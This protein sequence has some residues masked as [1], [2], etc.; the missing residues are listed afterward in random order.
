MKAL[1]FDLYLIKPVLIARTEPGDE[2]SAE[3]LAY[4]PGSSIRGALISAYMLRNKLSKLDLK[5]DAQARGWFFNDLC[6]LNAYPALEGTRALPA[7]LSWRVEK[8]Y[9]AAVDAEIWDAAGGERPGYLQTPATLGEAFSAMGGDGSPRLADPRRSM[10]IHNAS[11]ERRIKQAGDS[12]VFLYDALAA[13]QTFTA[14]ITGEA[15]ASMAEAVGL[16]DGARFSLGRSRSAHYGLVE[17]RNLRTVEDWREGDAL[18]AGQQGRLAL[19][20]A[21]D[22]LLYDAQGQPAFNL[23][24]EVGAPHSAA[25]YRTRVA[26]GFNRAWGL[27]LPQGLAIQAGSVFLYDLAQLDKHKLNELLERG[28]GDRRAEGFGRVRALV[29]PPVVLQRKDVAFAWPAQEQA[30]LSDESQKIAQAVGLQCLIGFLEEKLASAVAN[31]RVEQMEDRAQLSRLRM[32]A[33]SAVDLKDFSVITRHLGQLKASA[34]KLKTARVVARVGGV[35]KRSRLNEWLEGLARDGAA[36]EFWRQPGNQDGEPGWNVLLALSE[37][38]RAGMVGLLPTGDELRRLK[39]T[40]LGRLLDAVLQKASREIQ[41]AAQKE[42][43]N[44]G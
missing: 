23:D 27:P 10:E 33:R 31:L 41:R 15:A 26:G 40:Y 18:P 29:N 2:N 11:W 1:L 14:V 16:A 6:F 39:I 3:A 5:G 30:A 34:E 24:A 7:P 21:S 20:L 8:D 36:Q 9:R 13:G 17:V 43:R 19:V 38:D 25:W 37:D 4:L 12:Q 28:V 22:A 32:A 42:V 35:E 44:G